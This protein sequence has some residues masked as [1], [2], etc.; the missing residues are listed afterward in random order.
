MKKK[1]RAKETHYQKRTNQKIAI[2]CGHSYLNHVIIIII[3]CIMHLVQ[4]KKI[5]KYFSLRRAI[6]H[7][8]H[9]W[10]MTHC[11]KYRE[12]PP[13]LTYI[14]PSK[15][16]FPMLRIFCI[17]CEK[18]KNKSADIVS[19]AC[20]VLWW[21]FGSFAIRF[22]IDFKESNQRQNSN[23]TTTEFFVFSF[24]ITCN[25]IRVSIYYRC[26]FFVDF[27]FWLSIRSFS[28]T[29]VLHRHQ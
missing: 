15:T 19:T 22:F 28:M 24:I 2:Q 29:Y 6:C 3:I 25:H 1:K 4:K 16:I 9:S 18:N 13:Y 5:L 21:A 23:D 27:Q 10:T 17:N 26:R 7:W 11:W 20:A 12:I 8:N 14:Q